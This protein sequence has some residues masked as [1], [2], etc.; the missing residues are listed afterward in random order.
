MYEH[1]NKRDIHAHSSSAARLVTPRLVTTRRRLRASSAAACSLRLP[2]LLHLL[3]QPLRVLLL[4]LYKRG[5][6]SP[7]RHNRSPSSF[8]HKVLTTVLLLCSSPSRLAACIAGRDNRPPKPHLLSPVREKGDKVF[9]ECSARLLFFITDSDDFFPDVHDLLDDMAGEDT[10]PKSSASTAAVPYVFL[11]F[12]L[13]VLPQFLVL[14]L[15]L[16]MLGSTS[17]MQRL[18]TFSLS[19]RMTCFISSILVMLYLV[20]LLIKSFGKLLIFPTED[21]LA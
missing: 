1:E 13:K 8:R 7:E 15:V 6:S 18:F 16:H 10:D 21:Y 11:S 14:V 20:F 17:Y 4:C 5:R 12:L 3:P 9:G 19:E 2:S